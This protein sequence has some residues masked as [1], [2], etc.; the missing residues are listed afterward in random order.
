MVIPQG[1]TVGTRAWVFLAPPESLPE[2]PPEAPQMLCYPHGRPELVGQAELLA[3]S[4]G[5]V[6]GPLLLEE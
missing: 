4:L 3:G 5:P 1:L 2:A 6:V